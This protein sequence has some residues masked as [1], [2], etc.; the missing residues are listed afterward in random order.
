MRKPAQNMED[1]ARKME[2]SFAGWFGVGCGVMRLG[3]AGAGL[4]DDEAAGGG[5]EDGGEEAFGFH[6]FGG[7]ADDFVVGAGVVH[8]DEAVGID[9][10]EEALYFLLAD[11]H[12]GVR[13][14]EVDGA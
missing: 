14:E 8:E 13:E 4:G 3:A 11:G 5:Q 9:L 2:E 1:G 6:G 10:G 7:V 12:I